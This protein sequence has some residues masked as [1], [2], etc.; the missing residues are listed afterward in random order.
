M[1]QSLIME[2]PR[3][4]QELKYEKMCFGTKTNE[5]EITEMQDVEFVCCE[6]ET[7]YHFEMRLFDDNNQQYFNI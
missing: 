4:R 3:C 6:C 1:L 5:F 7:S 2:C